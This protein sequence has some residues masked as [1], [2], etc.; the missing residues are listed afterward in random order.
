MKGAYEMF[1]L[2]LR[3]SHLALLRNLDQFA[4]LSK[5][6]G[7]LVLNRPNGEQKLSGDRTAEY[8]AWYDDFLD[9]H[10]HGEDQHIF[11]ALR[12]HSAGR[13]TDV[14]HLDTWANEHAEIYR[15][16]RELRSASRRLARGTSYALDE[17]QRLALGLKQL[18]TPHLRAEEE[19][20]TPEHLREMIPEK[21]LEHAQLAIPKSQ[22]IGAVR[23]AQFFAH[24]LEP[25]EQRALLGE[26]PWFFRKLVLGALGA[27]KTR[28]FG[29]LMPVRELAL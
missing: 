14:A 29:E 27:R 5:R 4:R 9:L 15:L 10:H 3:L 8:I 23:M 13:S 26:T 22:G 17:V 18:L 20:L 7:T 2:G 12:K 6:D 11:P 19:V 28:R 1:P 16:S 25:A 21:E 24:S